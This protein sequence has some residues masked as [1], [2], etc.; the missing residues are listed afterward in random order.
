MDSATTSFD[1]RSVRLSILGA[2]W[3]VILLAIPLW[4]STTSIERLSLPDTRVHAQSGRRLHFP[5]NVVLD[6][7]RLN[8]DT[9]LSLQRL[10]RE[11]INEE[12]LGQDEVEPSVVSRSVS[13]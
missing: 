7:V 12:S 3:A 13:A 5:V 8:S 6:D 4:W 11:R 1:K 9:A 10:L 2:Y